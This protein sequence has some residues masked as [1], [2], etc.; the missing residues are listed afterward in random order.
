MSRN[1]RRLLIAAAVLTAA[2]VVI[3]AP[4]EFSWALAACATSG[5]I[6][7]Q[8]GRTRSDRDTAEALAVERRRA[9]HWQQEAA[10]RGAD[11]QAAR[12][13]IRA[14]T[15]THLHRKMDGRW[16]W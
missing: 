11:L 7:H 2:V 14:Q 4:A 6:G 8:V 15:V 13:E 16:T 12:D 1:A 9:A 10:D 5:W 3:V